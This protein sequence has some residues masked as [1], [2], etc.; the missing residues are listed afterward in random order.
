MARCGILGLAGLLFL[1]AAA[2]AEE[3]S[4]VTGATGV[5]LEILRQQLDRFE[6]YSGNKVRIV[7]RPSNPASQF[8][9]YRRWLDDPTANID[10][11]GMEATWA[12]QLAGGLADLTGS[13]ADVAAAHFPVTI[14]A[15]TV[16][17]RLMA[18]PFVAEAPVLFYR[19]DLLDRHGFKPPAT[20]AELAATAKAVMDKERAAGNSTMW[21]YVFQGAPH[22]GLTGNALE[23]IASNGGGS[24]VDP[25][26]TVTV[27]NP[28]AAAALDRARSWIGSI[29]PP[30]VLNFTEEESRAVFQA[31]NAVFM[32]NWPY[33]YALGNATD[34]AVR[35]RFDIA[36]L[37]AGEGGRS[38]AT[39]GGWTLALSKNSPHREAGT[40]LIRYLAASEAQGYRALRAADLPTLPVLYGDKD[41]AEEQP[42]MAK[43]RPVIEN[44]V[45]RPAAVTGAKYNDVSK[46]FWSAVYETLSGRGSA[47]GNLAALKGRLE[48]LRGAAW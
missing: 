29:A 34:S 13:T 39:L 5:D 9:D 11:Y 3:L 2:Q 1:A 6:R 38:A 22:E 17:G 16:D 21:G 43:W 44:A 37:P 45:L 31:G 24:I 15:Q 4:I 18:L 32:R 19:K 8:G 12:P 48:S 33:A 36:P 27:D 46:E 35:G 10:V 25:D 14:R 28:K 23:W 30:D 47:A 42:G 7:A 41:I 40:A 20:W 26:G